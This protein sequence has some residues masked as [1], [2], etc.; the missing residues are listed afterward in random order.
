MSKMKKIDA[1]LP[2]E[3]NGSIDALI[4]A[5]NSGKY[6]AD[7]EVSQVLGDIN[8]SESYGLIDT[9]FARKLREI[10]VKDV[11]RGKYGQVLWF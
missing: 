5:I 10:Y 6:P 9:G 1:E 2:K 4:L 7:C 11:V 8:A 3:L